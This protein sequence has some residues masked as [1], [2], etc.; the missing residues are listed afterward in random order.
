MPPT[1]YPATGRRTRSFVRGPRCSKTSPGVGVEGGGGEAFLVVQIALRVVGP[2]VAHHRRPLVLL[3]PDDHR[4]AL[5]RRAGLH[6][7]TELA[8]DVEPDQL[9]PLDLETAA[10]VLE[11]DADLV[12]DDLDRVELRPRMDEL[13]VAVGLGLGPERK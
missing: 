9:V 6:P 12:A 2:G 4:V 13:R 3:A 8:G 5:E 10:D 7:A 1:R 11:L